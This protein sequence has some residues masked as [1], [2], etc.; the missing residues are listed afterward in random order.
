MSTRQIPYNELDANMIN[1]VR[2]LNSYPGVTTIGSCGGHEEPLKP[3]QWSAGTW[4][5]KFD[6]S[7]D[8]LGWYV[9]EFLAW[10]INNDAARTLASWDHL[11]LLPKA[12]PPYLNTPGDMLSFVLESYNGQDPDDLAAFLEKVRP[13]FILPDSQ[14]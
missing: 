7:K 12:A 1:L 8:R 14:T 10:A 3:G 6:I 11:V 2:A 5:V 13:E 4:Y 9:L